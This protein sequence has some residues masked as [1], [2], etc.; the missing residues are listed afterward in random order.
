MNTIPKVLKGDEIRTLI[1][2][3]KWVAIEIGMKR[4]NKAGLINLA[5]ILQY[6]TE[7]A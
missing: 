3:K 4:L 6:K 2:M 5:F 7:N 1:G